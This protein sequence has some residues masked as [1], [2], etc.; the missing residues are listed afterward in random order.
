MATI[1]I[2]GRTYIVPDETVSNTASVP[3]KVKRRRARKPKPAAET[4]VEPEAD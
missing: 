4:P 3:V 1:I 2:N